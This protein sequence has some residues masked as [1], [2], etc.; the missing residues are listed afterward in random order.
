M[1]VTP[2][3][4]NIIGVN[5]RTA[6]QK[7]ETIFKTRI[8]PKIRPKAEEYSPQCDIFLMVFIILGTEKTM[9]AGFLPPP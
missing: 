8:V 6:A 5:A 9:A 4:A 3:L 7:V 1:E 2:V